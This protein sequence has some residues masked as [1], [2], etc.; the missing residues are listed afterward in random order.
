MSSFQANLSE[1]QFETLLAVAATLLPPV[2][3]ETEFEIN[4]IA[5]LG[6]PARL[7]QILDDLPD[8]RIGTDLGLALTLLGTRAGGLVLYRK[9]TAF[10]DL[11]EM[12]R[13]AALRAMASSRLSQARQVYSGLKRLI[14]LATFAANPTEPE[15]LAWPAMGY[16]GPNGPPPT[17]PKPISPLAITEDTTID[18]DVVI[19]GSGAGGGVAASV[20]AEAGLD[21]VVLEKGGYRNES[22]FTHYEAEAYRTMYLDGLQTTTADG[23]VNMVAGST[24]GGG[25]VVNYTTSFATPPEVCAQWDQI[26]GLTGLFTGADYAA[27]S[28]AVH[29]RLSV[30][31]DHNQPSHRDGTMEKG[32]RELGWHVDAMPRNVSGCDEDLCGYCT[33]GCRHEA[34]QSTMVTYLQHAFE[35]GARIIVAAD[36]KRVTT[37]A[38]VATGVEARVGSHSLTVRA[39]AVVLAAGS[40]NTPAIML[41]SGIK[42]STVGHN[43]RL[44]PAFPMWGD[45]DETFEPW[46]GIMQAL[47]SDQ[48]ADLD[49]NGYGVKFETAP[50]HPV[51]LGVLNPWR[52]GA[53]FKKLITR[54]QHTNLIGVLLRD[55]SQGRVTV[56]R[57]GRPVW[58]YRLNKHDV[59]HL[60]E[61]AMRAAEVLAAS[62]AN[63]VSTPTTQQVVWSPKGS[64]SVED[65]MLRVDSA[66]YGAGQFA[67][68]SWHQMGTAAM[69]ANPK[70]S[71]VDGD[72]EVHGTPNLFVLDAS[73]FPASSGVN[74]M[75]SIQTI[76]H[77]G[78]TALAAR[79]TYS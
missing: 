56:D 53:Q 72:N 11:D 66:G 49:G 61:G 51:F 43:L 54:Y 47:Y 9:P 24:L 65:F 31:Q 26:S 13:Q 19:V 71:V 4:T 52:S 38:D 37:A 30:N 68:S 5:G 77:R 21:V 60:R 10:V 1:G 29:G 33:M 67:L 50:I 12:G 75:I 18:C 25:T 79:L 70:R 34:K 42:G 48:F 69:G 78:A 32:L 58:K 74:P 2:A 14:S 36:V 41:R 40:L 62:G 63:E 28:E 3:G 27:S 17:I 20:L 35:L 22:D 73:T 8:E 64:E 15:P 76:A 16:P 44:H 7:R 55:T 39:R 23:S 57:K 59:A 6:L 46:S 45:F